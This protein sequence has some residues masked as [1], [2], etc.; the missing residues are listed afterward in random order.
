MREPNN[1]SKERGSNIVEMAVLMTLLLL[2]VLGVIDFGR[3]LYI[4]IEVVNAVRAGALY[5]AQGPSTATD[6]TGITFAINNESADLSSAISGIVAGPPVCQCVGGGNV[7]CGTSGGCGAA[8]QIEWLTVRASV[9]YVPW[10]KFTYFG[11]PASFLI[12]SSATMPVA[13]V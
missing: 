1:R 7:T 5:G 3:L 8:P 13:G 10:F 4:K 11:L 2:M 9:V 12:Q 6:T